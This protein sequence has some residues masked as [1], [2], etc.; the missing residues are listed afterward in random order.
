[1]LR[2][3]KAS[4]EEALAIKFQEF[5]EI[6]SNQEPGQPV[7]VRA[8]MRHLQRLSGLTRFKQR[9]LVD[10]QMLWDD[11]LLD[12]PFEAQ[13][14]VLPFQETSQDQIKQLLQAT[15]RSNI[16]EMERL[17]QR[18]Q[19]PDLQLPGSRPALHAACGRRCSIEAV[20]LLLEAKADTDIAASAPHGGSP[21]HVVSQNGHAEVLRLLMEAKADKDRSANYGDT[22]MMVASRRGQLEILRLLLDA[23]A[24]MDRSNYGG[25]T[26][27]FMASRA[28]HLEIMRLLLEANADK[29]KATQDGATSLYVA[30]H[31]GRLDVVRLLLQAS[32][33]KDKVINDGTTSTMIASRKGHLEIVRLLLE[34]KAD[35]DTVSNDGSTAMLAASQ[36]GHADVVQLLLDA[37]E[38]QA[39]AGRATACKRPRIQY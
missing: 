34:A 18:P 28:G 32:A 4:G 20:H 30:S 6:A 15:K 14:V 39:R 36:Q 13:L 38:D 19:D 3:F 24:D 9:L 22:P 21:M 23:S 33:D 11:D 16:P 31:W 17:L 26:P 12:R 5:L 37:D 27:M 29:D 35:K 25:A 2:V 1:M 7:R 10:T 8:V